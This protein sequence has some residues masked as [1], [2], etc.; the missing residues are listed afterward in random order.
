M[1]SLS[2]AEKR[3]RCGLSIDG[4]ISFEIDSREV[5]LLNVGMM[6]EIDSLSASRYDLFSP[7]LQHLS[8][9][10]PFGNGLKLGDERCT[11]LRNI[12]FI[13]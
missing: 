3:R 6:V 5:K 10:S 13:D 9:V 11:H 12:R 1:R 7:S 2:K 8:T 4:V